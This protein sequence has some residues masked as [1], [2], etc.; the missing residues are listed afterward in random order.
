MRGI[1]YENDGEKIELIDNDE[2]Y[3]MPQDLAKTGINVLLI[4]IHE[5]FGYNFSEFYNKE[6]LIEKIK[7]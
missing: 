2:L 5:S 1:L 7:E 4:R 6:L 3:H